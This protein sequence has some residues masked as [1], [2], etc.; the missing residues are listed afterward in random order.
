MSRIVEFGQDNTVTI[1]MNDGQSVTLP[2]DCFEY[3]NPREG[4]AV[5][6]YSVNGETKIYLHQD[7][8]AAGDVRFYN[9][10]IFTWVFCFLLGGLGV[11]RFLRG[12]IALGILKLITIDGLGIWWLVD[13]IIACNK[14]YGMDYRDTE[15]FTFING[16]YDR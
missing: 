7:R 8:A 12:Q 9:K 1:E 13:W 16:Y 4:D 2:M 5:D 10:H 11:D 6:V 3:G 15:D 14:A